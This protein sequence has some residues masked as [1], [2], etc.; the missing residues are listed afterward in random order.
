MN[1]YRLS[2]SGGRSVTKWGRVLV[3]HTPWHLLRMWP[4]WVSS[5][6]GNCMFTLFTVISG[7]V[8]QLP[9]WMLLRQFDLVGN[10]ANKYSHQTARSRLGIS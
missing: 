2:S 10:P 9:L 4:F 3:E 7:Q 8:R 5:D 6:Y 1:T